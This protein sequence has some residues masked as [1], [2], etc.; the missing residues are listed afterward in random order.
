MSLLRSLNIRQKLTYAIVALTFILAITAGLVSGFKLAG[1]QSEALGSKGASL[2]HVLAEAVTTS[3]LSD[4][5]GTTSGAMERALDFAKGDGEVSA[6]AVVV[7]EAGQPAKVKAQKVFASAPVDLAAL[8]APL[9]KG[10][11]KAEAGGFLV[12]ASLLG[13]E[14]QSPT[15]KAYQLVVLNTQA[16]TARNRKSA[17]IMVVLGLGM[18][19]LGLVASLLLAAT[20]VRP[21]DTI[22]QRMRDISEGAGDLTARL[23]VEGD[24][25]VAQLSRYFNQFVANIQDIVNQVVTI[26]GSIASGSLEMT[27][28]MAEMAAT[29]EAIAHTAENQKSSVSQ[30]NASVGTIAS[31]SQVINTQVVDALQVFDQAQEAAARGETAVGAAVSGMRTINENSKQIGNILSVITDMA[32]QTNLLSLNAA[33]EAA[34]AGEHGKG[35]AV[36]AEEVRKLAERSAIAAKDIAGLIRTSTRSIE[37]GSGMVSTAG[38][39]L[40]SIDQAIRASMERMRVIGSHSQTQ[41][42]DSSTVVGAMGSLS[43]IADGNAAATEEMAATL[44]ETARTVQELSALA[45][46][47][48]QLV[49]RFKI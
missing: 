41:S 21:L 19:G 47:L 36:V 1:A 34:K 24:D 8:A 39:A 45:E 20:I 32:N 44:R 29:A 31:A 27:A 14:A 2:C 40:Q 7:V 28:G 15:A 37:D 13:Q 23:Q 18:M 26:S 16:I 49:S 4:D 12:V 38:A 17:L 25:E 6:A 10:Q 35:F 30:A 5:L 33:I 43:G 48:S 22:Q 3:F 11:L 9:G 42:R 46:Q